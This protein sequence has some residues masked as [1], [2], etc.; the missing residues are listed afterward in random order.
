ME[1]ELWF[2]ME[3]ENALGDGERVESQGDSTVVDPT[4][5]DPTVTAPLKRRRP[6]V[7]LTAERLMGEKGLPYVMK[8]AP[9]RVRISKRR[10]AHDNLSH[11]I[12]FYQLW[13]HE[14]YPKARFG[15]FLKLCQSLG[16]SDRVL[17]EYRKDLYREELLGGSVA[18]QTREE[19][20]LVEPVE[21]E[22]PSQEV[23]SQE[24]QQAL[25][26]EQELEEPEDELYTISARHEQPG[27][28]DL[29][30]QDAFEEDQEAMEAMRE[31]G[32]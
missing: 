21:Q 12:Q 13:A 3:A 14:L 11:M 8:H 19:P 1:S 25:M 26:A 24:E 20:G 27:P 9:K 23:P 2:G 28:A 17:R 4:V 15:D 29:D 7:K 16:K 18:G 5:A 6:Q 22:A 31:L 32:F 10:N 30:T